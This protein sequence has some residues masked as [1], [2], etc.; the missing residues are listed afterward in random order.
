MDKCAGCWADGED[1]VL[2]RC[3]DGEVYC[4]KC[5]L[6][7]ADELWADTLPDDKLRIMD[8]EAINDD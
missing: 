2:Y 4:Q 5:A 7:I 8:F 1:N 6:R 3:V